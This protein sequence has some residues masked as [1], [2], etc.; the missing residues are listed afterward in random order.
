[1]RLPGMAALRQAHTEKLIS[2]HTRAMSGSSAGA[3]DGCLK[4]LQL[5]RG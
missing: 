4:R 2:L 3:G 1:M 5:A